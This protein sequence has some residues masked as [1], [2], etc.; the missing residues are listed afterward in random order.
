MW[1][2]IQLWCPSLLRLTFSTM[3]GYK[4]LTVLWMGLHW[5][6]FKPRASHTDP[7]V[8]LVP[9]SEWDVE[10]RDKAP[11]FDELWAKAACLRSK[12]FWGIGNAKRKTKRKKK[13]NS[14]KFISSCYD[15]PLPSQPCP[16]YVTWMKFINHNYSLLLFLSR[17]M[18]QAGRR[19]KWVCCQHS[20]LEQPMLKHN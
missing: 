7:K 9:L 18:Q 4:H 14:Y 8:Y 3:S 10:G 19:K 13:K 11:V 5:V 12:T 6:C 2:I 15:S 16:D 1:P 20:R 17:E